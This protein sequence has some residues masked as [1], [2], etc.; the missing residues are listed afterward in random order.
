MNVETMT[1]VLPVDIV[2]QMRKTESRWRGTD[3]KAE[4]TWTVA[5]WARALVEHNPEP[6]PPL[7]TGDWVTVPEDDRERI[8]A[9]VTPQGWVSSLVWDDERGYVWH[10]HPL[11]VDKFTRVNAPEDP[12]VRAALLRCIGREDET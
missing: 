1:V 7:Q 11:T 3:P 9:S 8:V 6:E 4:G 10:D 12:E 5:M 2:D